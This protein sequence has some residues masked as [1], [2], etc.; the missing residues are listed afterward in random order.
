M[1]VAAI[2]RDEVLLSRG[3]FQQGEAAMKV[4][5]D[6]GDDSAPV[7]LPAQNGG[8]GGDL[9]GKLAGKGGE[10]YIGVDADAGDGVVDPI[11]FTGRFAE[12]TAEFLSL[13]ENVVGPFELAGM[14]RAAGAID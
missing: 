2:L 14:P 3:I 12:D 11:R 8:E 5:D 10:R 6:F 1:A 9:I 7:D 4:G 13:P